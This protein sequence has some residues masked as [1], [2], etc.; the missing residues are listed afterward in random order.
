MEYDLIIMSL[1]IFVPTVFALGLLFFPRGQDEAVR[2]WS[3]LGTTVTLVLSLWLFIDYLHMLQTYNP[4]NPEGALLSDRAAKDAL[5]HARADSS[6][7]DDMVARF[8]WIPRLN[9]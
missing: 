7:S 5:H 2:W 4:S 6:L 9:I 1:V 3:L 8:P